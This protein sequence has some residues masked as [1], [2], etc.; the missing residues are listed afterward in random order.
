M[1]LGSARGRHPPTE[2]RGR[3]WVDFACRV[4]PQPAVACGSCF[5][6]KRII[7]THKPRAADPK[8][9][10]RSATTPRV[11]IGD[12]RSQVPGP[13]GRLSCGVAVV[14]CRVVERASRS[15]HTHTCHIRTTR[16]SRTRDCRATHSVTGDDDED[17]E[18]DDDDNTT[19]HRRRPANKADRRAAQRSRWSDVEQQA[20][21]L[22]CR[23][24][25]REVRTKK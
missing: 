20:S 22:R 16:A 15:H 25:G 1:H 10:R 4:L 14:P 5:F 18:R 3:P 21:H 24:P 9:Q 17:Y 7:H 12:R 8:T 6:C 2:R 23:L 11:P 13:L 19:I